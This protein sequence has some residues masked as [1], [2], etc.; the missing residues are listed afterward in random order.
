MRRLPAATGGP[1]PAGRR[2]PARIL[3]GGWPLLAVLPLL[4]GAA[5]A[6]RSPAPA[7]LAPGWTERGIASWYGPKFH[8]RRTASGEIY[9]MDAMTA[10]HRWLPFGTV[11]RVENRDNG[12][13]AVVRI[14]DRGPFVRGRIIDLSRAAARAVGML[15]RGT[16]RVRLVLLDLSGQPGCLELQ[17]GAFREPENA[18]AKRRELEAR[19]LRVREERTAGGLIR[20]LVGPF[21]RWARARTARDRFGGFLRACSS[22]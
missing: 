15:G 10:A 2:D 22:R 9:D 12:R 8:G 7:V 17:V 6:G 20:V 1:L 19:S 4:V 13:S 21:F 14:N 11:L 5:C 16:A 3:R 18:R